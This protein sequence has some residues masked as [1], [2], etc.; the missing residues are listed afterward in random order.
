MSVTW[1]TSSAS[2]LLR[3]DG[4]CEVSSLAQQSPAFPPSAAQQNR[5][6]EDYLYLARIHKHLNTIN[7]NA[8][9]EERGESRWHTLQSARKT[10]ATSI[11]T[12]KI[13]GRVSRWS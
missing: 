13:T 12:T 11:C 2:F 3:H 7:I 5:T 6:V 10:P 1:G 4:A 9:V 8:N